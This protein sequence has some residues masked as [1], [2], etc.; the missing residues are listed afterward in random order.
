MVDSVFSTDPG[1]DVMGLIPII[2]IRYSYT[3]DSIYLE[4]KILR[5]DDGHK[6]SYSS[7]VEGKRDPVKT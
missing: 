4:G 7:T 3:T 1:K 2:E 6:V 5:D